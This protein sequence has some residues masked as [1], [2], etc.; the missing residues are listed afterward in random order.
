MRFRK[1]RFLLVYPFAVGLFVTSNVSEFSLRLGALFLLLGEALRLWA[2]GYV[3]HVKVN[4][5]EKERTAQKIGQL[6]TAGPYEHIRHPLYLGT[7]LIG[8]GF[9]ITSRNIW[10]GITAVVLFSIVYNQKVREEEEVLLHEWGQEYD[11]Y[12]QLVPR[13]GIS[14][15]SYHESR[16]VWNWQGIWASKELKTVI[17]VII[18]LIALYL[19]KEGLRHP[20]LILLCVILIISDGVLELW[21]HRIEKN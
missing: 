9:C 18:C 13:W 3:G 12:Q 15:S 5:T 2:N 17:W 7:F 16:G 10:L 20:L 8:L 19:K 21:K 11:E 4:W 14:F 1:F 6:I